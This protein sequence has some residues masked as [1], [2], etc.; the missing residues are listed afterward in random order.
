ML[1]AL[2]RG[3]S[4]RVELA[5]LGDRPLQASKEQLADALSGQLTEAQRIV[6]ALYLE[7]IDQIEQQVGE[8]DKAL[9]R[10]LAPHQNA[11]ERLCDMPGVSVR[12][13]QHI[14]AETGPRADA[15]NSAGK[16]ASWAAM[17]PGQQESAGVC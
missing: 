12:T 1:D 7:Q 10:A 11:I 3:I 16:L 8:L 15:F 13:A 6:L 5:G 4:D 17:C 2:I 14:I 9:A